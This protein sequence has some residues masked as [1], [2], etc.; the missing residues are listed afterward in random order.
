MAPSNIGRHAVQ[1]GEL[2]GRGAVQ[3]QPAFF[4]AYAIN[5]AAAVL[6]RRAA[7]DVEFAPAQRHVLEILGVVVKR[8]GMVL[9]RLLARHDVLVEQRLGPLDAGQR[10]IMRLHPVAVILDHQKVHARRMQ[11]ANDQHGQQHH[12]PEHA[13]QNGTAPSH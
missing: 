4:I 7:K 2:A 12:A 3:I 13:D 6:R 1:I 5:D 11:D 8:A 10:Q 9:G